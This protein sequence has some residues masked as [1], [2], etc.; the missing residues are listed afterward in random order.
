MRVRGHAGLFVAVGCTAVLALTGCMGMPTSGPV[1]GGDVVVPEPENAIP[2]PSGPTEGATPEGIV[3]GFLAAAAAGVYDDFGTAKSFLTS[4]AA[5]KWRPQASTT[6]YLTQDPEVEVSEEDRSASVTVE[7][8]GTVDDAG[9]YTEEVD[10]AS[11]QVALTLA[12]VGGEWRISGV[13]DGVLM[14][15]NSFQGAH[16]PVRVYFAS[17]DG[18]QLIP[19]Q[20]W[21]LASRVVPEA[22]KALVDGPS[23]WLRDGVTTGV[24]EGVR[25][26]YSGITL[27]DTVLTVGLASDIGKAPDVEQ[28]NLLQAQLEATMAS[29][30]TG[31]T[32]IKVTINDAPWEPSGVPELVVDPAPSAGPFVISHDDAGTAVL[33]EVS[34]R[35]VV[36]V[37]DAAPLG[38]LAASS[39]AISQDGTVR[40]VL[41]AGRRLMLVP[42]DSAQPQALA[43]GTSLLP[44]SIDRFDWVWTGERASAG[45]LMA[46]SPAG[47]RVDVAAAWLSDRQIR[48]VRVARDGARV[49]VAYQN[50]DGRSVVEV[51]AVVRDAHGRPQRLSDD[52]LVVGASLSE[53]TEVSW[54]D[55][56][57]LAVLGVGGAGAAQGAYV[58]PLG[59]PSEGKAAQPGVVNIAA[60]PDR[61]YVADEDDVLRRFQ[62][63]T[64]A[65]VA[66]DVRDPVFPG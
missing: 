51:A 23:P 59:G 39:P 37:A 33:A 2:I 4:S 55:E 35:K 61:L 66:E 1:Q 20:R 45:T 38:G 41:D 19:E 43:E 21:F 47:E 14:S 26:L 53:V 49:A 11:L 52:R 42:P 18:R 34:D 64:W 22:A 48:S 3:N 46:V 58:V 28:R 65:E 62:L 63:S 15:L 27:Q 7:P 56:T 17:P 36:P 10:G 5:Q 60:M 25:L 50:S 57:N 29:T 8:V 16:R 32:E 6:L 12:Q 54:L 9:R 44:P 24:P 40:V 30:N 13:P 31:V